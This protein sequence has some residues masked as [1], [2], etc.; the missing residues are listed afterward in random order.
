M[1][2]ID[3]AE[4]HVAELTNVMGLVLNKCRYPS[5]TRGHVYGKY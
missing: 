2:Q 4:R 1:S 5:K 3:V